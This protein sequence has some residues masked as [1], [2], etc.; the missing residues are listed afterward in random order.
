MDGPVRV[1]LLRLIRLLRDVHPKGDFFHL[2]D[3]GEGAF[4]LA[5]VRS[6]FPPVESMALSAASLDAPNLPLAAYRSVNGR[7][8][9]CTSPFTAF[10][11]QPMVPTPPI[12]RMQPIVSHSPHAQSGLLRFHSFPP[13]ASNSMSRP[14]DNGSNVSGNGTSRSIGTSTRTPLPSSASADQVA[15]PPVHY[16]PCSFKGAGDKALFYKLRRIYEGHGDSWD[17]ES[18]SAWFQIIPKAKSSQAKNKV[19]SHS[20]ARHLTVETVTWAHFCFLKAIF[21]E[22]IF[23][24]HKTIKIIQARFPSANLGSYKFDESFRQPV[25]GARPASETSSG[26]AMASPTT[27]P[28][29]GRRL[30]T[31]QSPA[32]QAAPT[33]EVGQDDSAIC[34]VGRASE[35]GD[36]QGAGSATLATTAASEVKTEPSGEGGEEAGSATLAATAG[37]EVKTE[38]K[39]SGGEVVSTAK[40]KRKRL[41]DSAIAH[42][43]VGRDGGGKRAKLGGKESK[44]AADGDGDE[45]HKQLSDRLAEVTATVGKLEARVARQRRTMAELKAHCKRLWENQ[46]RIRKW[47]TAAQRDGVPLAA[48]VWAAIRKAPP[49]SNEGGEGTAT[50]EDVETAR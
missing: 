6:G 42:V 1:R 27:A 18:R 24:A 10:S 49:T 38:P 21:K 5:P 3:D 36:R 41:P 33:L 35:Q 7:L 45:R 25:P 13:M 22:Q 23:G 19:S 40:S 43:L 39:G 30:S 32:D 31:S 28:P 2:R 48:D 34:G 46:Q 15:R 44:A 17:D 50:A 9:G 26:G 12:V 8:A 47:V 20:V 14:T 37:S 11:M 4:R 16:P 29:E